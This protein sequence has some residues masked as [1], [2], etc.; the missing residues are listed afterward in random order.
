VSEVVPDLALV[1]VNYRSGRD[2]RRAVAS[3]LAS[4]G[5]LNVDAVVVDNAS[6][7][8]SLEAL[9]DLAGARLVANQVNR[10][11][12]AACNQA[13]AA[14]T[15]R[16]ILFLNP[17]VAAL[18]FAVARLVAALDARPDV[19]ILGGKLLNEDGSLQYSCRAFY[20][21]PTL[22][23]RRTPVGRLF[24]N[25]AA[26][27]RHLYA[28]W[29]H[30]TER[31]V[32]WLIGACLL[33][34]RDYY[35]RQ[36]GF[37]ERFFL[38]FEDVDLCWRAWQEGLRVRYLPQAVFV[39]R[40]RRASARLWPSRA[41]REHALSA[42]R[43]FAKHGVGAAPGPEGETLPGRMPVVFVV[44]EMRGA[45]RQRAEGL[46]AALGEDS[47]VSVL[48][49]DRY[50]GSR[51]RRVIA[52][53]LAAARRR[54]RAVVV[55]DVGFAGLF[56][57]AVL[58]ATTRSR[59]ILDT[60]DPYR[61]LYRRTGAG[62]GLA[63]ELRGVVERLCYALADAITARGQGLV[64]KLWAEGY[65]NISFLPD[66]IDL[67]QARTADPRDLRARLGLEGKLAVLTVG[68]LL[69]DRRH[70]RTYGWDLVQALARLRDRPVVGVVIGD[71]PGRAWLE[72]RAR[73]LEVRDKLVFTGRLEQADL[74]DHLKAADV[75]LSTQSDD[76]LGRS[77]TTGKLPLY[78]AAG[79]YVLA[80][81][82]GEAARVLPE[83]ML[84]PFAGE[85]DPQYPERLAERLSLLLAEPE[86]LARG[87]ELV[88]IAARRYDYDLLATRL[89][90]L[91]EVA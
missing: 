49:K 81:R 74:L 65:N 82:V 78:M 4:A 44:N 9:K 12:A 73:V 60:G 13:A 15:G 37:D 45:M 58:K 84:V 50:F 28:D 48:A 26:N 2:A 88:A 89:K 41:K 59:L 27:R 35:L 54:P 16:Y 22:L 47:D 33:V 62:Q 23:L 69:M 53:A 11:F 29:D 17:D 79:R 25:A 71:G 51:P 66:G 10:G 52:L 20:D 63:L 70:D 7:D 64:E 1:V 18:D 67:D 72:A 38:Y 75:C 42:A 36:G 40:H 68:S 6:G 85:H 43:F 90:A 14:T 76:L 21:A 46:K 80:S 30:D 87:G 61:E 8:G 83:E 24:P 31:D 32:G 77:R 5:S 86:R 34:R 19:A 55:F 57:L 39:H 56:A 3:A 91:L